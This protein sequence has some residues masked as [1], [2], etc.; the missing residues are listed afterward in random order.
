MRRIVLFFVVT[1]LMASMVAASALTGV[2]Q[3]TGQY[4]AKGGPSQSGVDQYKANSPTTGPASSPTSGPASEE[5]SQPGDVLYCA[6]EWLREWHQ[7]QG[8]WYFWWYKWCHDGENEWLKVYDGWHWWGP[9]EE[10]SPRTPVLF[11]GTP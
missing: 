5:D 1:A 4:G 9:I 3:N 6:P 8:W 2:A 11:R 7:A 10:E